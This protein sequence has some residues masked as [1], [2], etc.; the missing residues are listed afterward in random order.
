MLVASHFHHRL[1]KSWFHKDLGAVCLQELEDRKRIQHL[2][3]LTQPIE[4][5]I[6]YH[7]DAKPDTLTIYPRV[8]GK[9]TKEN[10]PMQV[11]SAWSAAS[12]KSCTAHFVHAL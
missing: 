3:A 9:A 11:S 12:I 8:A 10:Q 4:Q 5:E 6:T 2:L 1:H 7:R